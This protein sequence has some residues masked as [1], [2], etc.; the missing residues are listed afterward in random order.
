MP[1]KGYNDAG[2]RRRRICRIGCLGIA[3]A[4]C[5][6]IG[7]GLGIGLLLAFMRLQSAAQSHFYI[8]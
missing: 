8:R 6:A 3:F 7:C 1:I 2:P 5:L 4:T